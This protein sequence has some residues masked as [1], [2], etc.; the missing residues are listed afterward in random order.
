[1]VSVTRQ[2]PVRTPVVRQL[3]PLECG[4]AALASVLAFFGKPAD[5]ADVRRSCGVNR[6]GVSALALVECAR[7]HG[8]E[9][10]GFRYT[11]DQALSLP[12]PSIAH[13]GFGHYV[14][15][16]GRQ[17]D[18]VY[19]NDP[20]RG[21]MTMTVSAFATSFS[22]VVLTFETKE[23]IAA[24][25]SG[26]GWRRSWTKFSLLGFLAAALAGFAAC[27]LAVVALGGAWHLMLASGDRSFD[28]ES[29]VVPL[30]VTLALSAL[31]A[32]VHVVL[33]GRA[34]DRF[35]NRE[36]AS[37]LVG[38]LRR[39]LRE[40]EIRPA[41]MIAA[42]ASP[43]ALANAHHRESWR[44]IAAI[45]APFLAV[46]L[47]IVDS[48]VAA[49]WGIAAFGLFVACY[50]IP[51]RFYE[52]AEKG[53]ENRIW[54]TRL[55]LKAAL[56]HGSL[57]LPA[58][59]T[60]FLDSL[61]KRYRDALADEAKLARI[62][63]LRILG[64]TVCAMFAL[65]A[66]VFLAFDA[67]SGMGIVAGFLITASA[68]AA[69]SALAFR[70]ISRFADLSGSFAVARGIAAAVDHQDDAEVPVRPTPKPDHTRRRGLRLTE[71][72]FGHNRDAPPLLKDVSVDIAP[73]SLIAVTGANGCGKTALGKL[74]AGLCKP[75]TGDVQV[76][77][78]S[79]TQAYRDGYL[80]YVEQEPI[81]IEATI[82]ANVRFWRDDLTDDAIGRAVNDACLRHV[83]DCREQGL[84]TALGPAGAP[85][86]RGERQRVELARALAGDPGILVLD[87]P[88]S[89][90]DGDVEVSIL[91]ALRRR[92]IGCLLLTQ[93]QRSIE[94][95]D[96]VLILA[97]GVV[98]ERGPPDVLARQD[99]PLS[100]LLAETK[101]GDSG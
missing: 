75:W 19:V 62:E 58:L 27:F 83:V 82:E 93:R 48:L 43:F 13:L 76:T 66:M 10:R 35:G 99:G 50:Q 88:F 56:A 79:C 8:L 18:R 71:V 9:A 52:N 60:A 53:R 22:G 41:S 28:A 14:V 3:S 69:G 7:H 36:A 51:D 65:A 45:Y 31:C 4:A 98:A 30:A 46:P 1:M 54:L 5:L 67:H 85:L 100:T 101:R 78:G 92:G 16:E 40:L 23:R 70:D 38:A 49:I 39:P 55:S 17:A 29:L 64:V 81:L 57:G 25:Q 84:S 87:E 21:R 94:Q 96:E 15:V 42:A 74:A 89:S 37:T 95:C 86:S 24:R 12:P 20:S 91:A 6:D 11:A 47:S 34:D 73:G 72:T 44:R 68:L 80:A 77:H 63:G 2:G 61:A 26:D 59:S 32:A 90:L 97:G 33:L